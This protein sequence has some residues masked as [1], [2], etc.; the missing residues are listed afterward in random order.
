M[1]RL[2][3]AMKNTE[4]VLVMTRGLREPRASLTGNLVAFDRYWN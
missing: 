2:W 4:P 1:A 3:R